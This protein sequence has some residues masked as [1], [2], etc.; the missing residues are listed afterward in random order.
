MVMEV[1]VDGRGTFQTSTRFNCY[2]LV[3]SAGP[4]VLISLARRRA[5]GR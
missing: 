1:R 2:G 5:H 4:F 3:R